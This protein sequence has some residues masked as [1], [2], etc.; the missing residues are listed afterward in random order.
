M[1]W[2]QKPGNVGREVD[3]GTLFKELSA[4]AETE[5]VAWGYKSTMSLAKRFGNVSF[6][7]QQLLGLVTRKD[8]RNRNYYSFLKQ[9]EPT[10]DEVTR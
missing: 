9:G 4:I 3:S 10:Y 8:N 5:K 7:L 2:L 6:N 1:V